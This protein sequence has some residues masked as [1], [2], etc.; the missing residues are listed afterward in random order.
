M[1][2]R[3]S[4]GRGWRWIADA[5]ALFRRAALIW[6]VLSMIM[7]LLALALSMIPVLGSYLLY[8]LTPLLLGGLMV[9]ARDTEAGQEIEIAHLFRGFVEN[10]TQLVTVGGVYLVGNVII[11]G[12]ALSLGG[13][14]LRQ[15]LQAAAAGRPEDV[16]PA[17]ANRASVAVLVAAALFLPLAMIV[18]FAP[19]LVI[20]EKVP[21]WRAMSLSLRACLVNVL[22]FLLYVA[23][24]SVLLLVALALVVVG[25]ALW[26][27]LAIL[28]AYTAYR[29]I[30]GAPVPLS[31]RT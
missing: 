26:V 8:L 17:A 11:A 6:I 22:P 29:D 15:V 9:A 30:F 16:D 24:M 18:W 10:A 20:L 1:M 27:P 5:F 25:L 21:A 4:F 3:V 23:V 7:L 12:F 19:A 28:S 14:D 2:R 31:E 13:E